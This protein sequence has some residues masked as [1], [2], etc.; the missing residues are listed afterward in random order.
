MERQVQG[1]GR[2][3]SSHQRSGIFGRGFKLG[4]IAG[5]EVVIDWSVALI[6]FLVFT[7][8]AMGVFPSWHPEWS[9]AATWVVAFAASLLFLLSILAHELAH[10]LTA[11]VFGIKVPRITLF[12]FGGLAQLDSEMTSPGEELAVA[13]AGPLMSI[14]LGL[15][16]IV[17]ATLLVSVNLVAIRTFPEE[18][19]ASLGPIATLLMWLGPINILLALFNLVP[20]FPLDGGRVLRALVWWVTGSID[21]GTRVAASLGQMFAWLLMGLGVMMALG[22]SVPVFG[23]GLLSGLWLVLIGWFLN[24]AARMSYQQFYL[25]RAL[26]HVPVS[27]VMRSNILSVTPDLSVGDLVRRFIMNSEQRA[28]PVV[29]TVDSDTMVGLVTLE[30]VRKVDT[31]AWEQTFV[32]SIMTPTEQL[33][34]MRPQAQANDALRLLAD[35][36][37]NQIPI[38]EAGHLLGVIRRQDIMKWLALRTQTAS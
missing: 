31:I 38:V 33:I 18:L 21:R 9:M 27:D 8:L 3:G 10:A 2:R 16:S 19:L 20:G 5:I 37:V 13:I 12:L 28:F 25:L 11:R 15:V 24:S 4:T 26:E 7:S 32:S 6:L 36:E 22:V 23:R 1:E 35:R 14:F 29:R 17:V 30:D 34:V